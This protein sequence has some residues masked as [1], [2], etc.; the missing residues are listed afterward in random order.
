MLIQHSERITATVV[1]DSEHLRSSKRCINAL[2]VLG[3]HV[4]HTKR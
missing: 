1:K 4:E 3:L 2:F